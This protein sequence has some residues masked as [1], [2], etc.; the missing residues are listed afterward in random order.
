MTLHDTCRPE[1][2]TIDIVRPEETYQWIN[3]V[4]EQQCDKAIIENVSQDV[5]KKIIE[6]VATPVY[7]NVHVTV[8]DPYYRN[9]F[10]DAIYIWIKNRLYLEVGCEL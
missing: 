8:Q 5:I 4:I 6:R 7:F 10:P 3:M 2:I 9:V 1:H